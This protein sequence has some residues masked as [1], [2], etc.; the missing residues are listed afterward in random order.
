MSGQI[1]HYEH[2]DTPESMLILLADI[3]YEIQGQDASYLCRDA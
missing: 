1:W 2:S 3:K